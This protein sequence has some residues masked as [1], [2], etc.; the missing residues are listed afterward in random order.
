MKSLKAEVTDDEMTT[1]LDHVRALQQGIPGI[2]GVRIG[3]N[4]STAHQGYTYGFV[5]QEG[6]SYLLILHHQSGARGDG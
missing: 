3:K 4:R 1:A 6:I 2:V 5:M